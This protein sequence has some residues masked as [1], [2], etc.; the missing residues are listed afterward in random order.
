MA[1]DVAGVIHCGC[2]QVLWGEDEEQLLQDADLH[3]RK[4]HPELVG[5]LSP[6]E[7]ARPA[8]TDEAAV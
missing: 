2:G 4:A 1:I 5:T 6:L 7:L 3:V 8:V